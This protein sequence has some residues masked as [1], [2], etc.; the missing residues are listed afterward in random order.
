MLNYNLLRQICQGNSQ[1]RVDDTHHFLFADV[2]RDHDT[3]TWRNVNGQVRIP[4]TCNDSV[5]ILQTTSAKIIR[6]ILRM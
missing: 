2:L 4:Y 5:F 6:H 3:Y 1:D